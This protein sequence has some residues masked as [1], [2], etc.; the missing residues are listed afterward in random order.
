MQLNA[1]LYTVLA[2]AA[3]GIAIASRAPKEVAAAAAIAEAAEMGT[4]NMV[5]CSTRCG[6]RK[7]CPHGEGFVSPKLLST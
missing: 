7:N 3:S 5:K 2:L 4:S 1:L 6:P